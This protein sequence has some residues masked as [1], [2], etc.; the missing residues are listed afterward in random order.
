GAGPLPEVD[1]TRATDST[2]GSTGDAVKRF[3]DAK[4]SIAPNATNGI[5]E[6]HTFTVTVLADDGTGVDSDGDGSTF[7]PASNASVTVTLTNSNGAVANPAGPFT[8]TTNGS[9][10]FQVPFTSNSAGTVTGHATASVLFPDPDGGGPLPAV[11]VNRATDGTHG[12]SGDAVK[13]FVAGSLRWKK[14]DGQ[15]NLLGGATF[16]VTATEGTAVI[17]RHTPLALRILANSALDADKTDGNFLLNAY[18][19]FGGAAL[20]G[21]ALGTYTVQETVAPSGYNLDPM[22]LTAKITLGALNADLSGT[23]FVNTKPHLTITKAVT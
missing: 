22:V 5:T 21:L 13:T 10:Q 2:H 20:G 14:V 4:V 8:G 9:G 1:V 17:T 15:G 18:Q 7:D 3:V 16:L 12:S 23:P 11:T 6:S 19:S